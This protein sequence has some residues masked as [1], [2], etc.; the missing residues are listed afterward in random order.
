LSGLLLDATYSRPDAA[1]CHIASRQD[2][3][4]TAKLIDRLQLLAGLETHRFS[5]RNGN[6][7]PGTRV[8]SDAGLAR[9]HVKH[10]ETAQLDSVAFRQRLLHA[11]E[12]GFHGQLGFGLGD[13]GLVNHFVDMSSLITSSSSFQGV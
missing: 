9:A 6:L 12:D 1:R 10:A 2:A 13:A 7:R 4:A 8:A 3:G 11:L 5:R